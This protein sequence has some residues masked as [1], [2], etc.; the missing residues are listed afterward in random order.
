[1]NSESHLNS[2]I[3][4]T[5]VVKS[6]REFYERRLK[7]KC[8]AKD[9][10]ASGAAMD[11]TPNTRT[12]DRFSNLHKDD[13]IEIIRAWYR[14]QRCMEI[15]ELALKNEEKRNSPVIEEEVKIRHQILDLIYLTP[16][17]TPLRLLNTSPQIC[18][19]KE[20]LK[21]ALDTVE[22]FNRAMKSRIQFVVESSLGKHQLREIIRSLK[23]CCE[24]EVEARDFP[25][26][27][28]LQDKA[29]ECWVDTLKSFRAIHSC[30]VHEG[31]AETLHFLKK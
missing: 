2:I 11:S 14:S 7:S 9:A 1:M 4:L 29:Q 15:Y 28:E 5:K 6:A 23:Q 24:L 17:H 18:R 22:S 26:N 20:W 10:R 16:L 21:G 25:D 19:S 8:V 12:S 30:L 31:E 3:A 13:Q 27:M